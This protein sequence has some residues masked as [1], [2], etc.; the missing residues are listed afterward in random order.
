[1]A[2]A[3]DERGRQTNEKLRN[4]A[5]QENCHT[6]N[7]KPKWTNRSAQ[8]VMD[9]LNPGRAWGPAGGGRLALA[10]C[11]KQVP[12]LTVVLH[13]LGGGSSGKTAPRPRTTS[14]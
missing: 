14:K 5:S 8:K 7:Q 13:L 2:S 9:R 3:G 6:R 11:N 10:H 1:M 4:H 12:V